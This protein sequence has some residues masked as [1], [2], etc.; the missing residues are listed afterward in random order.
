VTTTAQGTGWRAILLVPS[1]LMA[2][3]IPARGADLRVTLAISG[4][5]AS[6]EAGIRRIIRVEIGDL[7]LDA[8]APAA[9]ASRLTVRCEGG[10]GSIAAEGFD[11][12]R[13]ADRRLALGDFPG[14]A[15]PRALALAAIEVLAAL[16]PAVR[17][18]LQARQIAARPPEPSKPIAADS[19]ITRT[20]IGV[21]AGLRSFLAP[22]GLHAWGARVEL[23]RRLA[24]PWS[25][26]FDLDSGAAARDVSL[27]QTSALLFSAGTSLGVQGGGSRVG[28]IV[29]L[30][31]RAGVV[32]LAGDPG[33]APG[34]V[35]GSAVQPWGGPAISGRVFAG[36]NRWTFTGSGEV[37]FAALGADGLVE[38]T[39]ALAASG[40]WVAAFIG[41]G[42][43]N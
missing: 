28:G 39:T 15:A 31:V 20:R 6:V 5:A 38:G 40:F 9:A 36:G 4:C 11:G 27:G 1:L 34:I 43:R 2:G 10:H 29:A 26:G 7:L 18:R 37:G 8:N 24:G 32:R 17:E 35:A 42:I 33:A 14:D 16:S 30:G 3:V 23:D 25:L 41:A 13:R 21:S 12:G 22:H 19:P